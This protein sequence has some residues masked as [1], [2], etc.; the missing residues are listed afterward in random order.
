MEDSLEDI[1]KQVEGIFLLSKIFEEVCPFFIAIGMT[2]DQFWR[3]DPTIAKYYYKAYLMKQKSEAEIN[4]W[5]MWKQ[6][7]YVYEAL[8]D[9]SPVL[10]A[11]SKKGTKPLPYPE[12]PY[13]I[14]K[15]DKKKTKQEEQQEAENERLKA[16]IFFN[17]WAKATK[18]RFDKGGVEQNGNNDRPSSN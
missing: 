1:S 15:M 13:G 6:G 14:E 7:V 8:C 12:R 10:H 2:Y 18:K 11:F 3:D 17:N 9:V 16:T 5:R 4:E